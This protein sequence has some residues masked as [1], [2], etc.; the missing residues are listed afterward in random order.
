MLRFKRIVLYL[1]PYIET[2]YINSMREIFNLLLLTIVLTSCQAQNT[3]L[4]LN[5]EKGKEYRQV[6][7]TKATVIQDINGQKMNMVITIKGSMLYKVVAVNPSDY[8]LDVKYESLG[9]VMDLPQGEIEFNSE[10]NDEQDVFSTLLSKMIGNTFNVKMAKNGKILDV[11]NIESRIESLFG[12]F[13]HLPENQLAQLKAQMNKAYGAEAFKGS[14]E[15]VTAIYPD[16]P[17]NKGDKWEIKTNLESGMAALMTTEYEFTDLG[18]DYATIKGVSVIET[19]D[20]DAYIEANG[21]PLKYDL[22]GSMIS[23]IKVDKETGWI[24]EATISQEIKGDAFVKENPQMPNGMKIPMIMINE[25]T[26]KN[27]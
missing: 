20:K 14:I 27:Q 13:T 10:K 22:K 6:A 9:M 21:M 15:M 4:T 8:D 16:N 11:K 18:S 19:E 17:V 23:D 24:I 26:I 12:D 5:L 3:D 2:T 1:Q 25:M 7:N